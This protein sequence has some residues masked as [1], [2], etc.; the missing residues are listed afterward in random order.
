ME[1]RLGWG[2]RAVKQK[3][4]GAWGWRDGNSYYHSQ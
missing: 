4:G 1:S 3:L 2:G